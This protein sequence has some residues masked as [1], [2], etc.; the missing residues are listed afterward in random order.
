M[1]PKLSVYVQDDLWEQAK[2]VDPNLN[3]SQVV[4]VALKRYALPTGVRLPFARERPTG[5]RTQVEQ[6]RQQLA[7]RAR[8]RY[9]YAYQ[10]GL[11]LASQLPWEAIEQLAAVGW[12]LDAWV[13]NSNAKRRYF[14]D[15]IGVGYEDPA[16]FHDLI[17]NA[18]TPEYTHESTFQAGFK[19][20]LQ[21][22]W[23]GVS[24]ND[25]YPPDSSASS[26][27]DDGMPDFDDLPFD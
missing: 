7:V 15:G 1:M 11:S 14:V 12:D 4:Q 19:D 10:M 26:A 16:P 5:A 13:R 22:V 23:G 18:I 8:E 27:I 17:A 9:E 6:I 21:D 25:D 24:S 20:A 3:A 2:A